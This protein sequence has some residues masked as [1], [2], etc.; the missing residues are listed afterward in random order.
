[1]RV[2]RKT[3]VFVDIHPKFERT[4][5]A[6]P[7]QGASFLAGEPYVLD[8]LQK[9]DADV[10]TSVPSHMRAGSPFSFNG[11]QPRRLTLLRDHVVVYRIDRI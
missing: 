9:M 10:F 5:K 4:L 6:K 1:M 8:Y 2:A 11:W 3:V 7:L